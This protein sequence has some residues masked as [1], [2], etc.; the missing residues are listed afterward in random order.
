MAQVPSHWADL[1]PVED[2]HSQD[3]Q[4]EQDSQFEEDTRFVAGRNTSPDLQQSA[5]GQVVGDSHTE[6][7]PWVAWDSRQVDLAAV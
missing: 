5:L 4:F 1:L 6:D 2:K 3:T 7:F